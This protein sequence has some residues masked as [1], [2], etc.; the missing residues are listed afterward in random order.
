LISDKIPTNDCISK[1]VNGQWV[2]VVSFPPANNCVG[3]TTIRLNDGTIPICIWQNAPNYVE[4][5]ILTGNWCDYYLLEDCSPFKPAPYPVN[6][7]PAGCKNPLTGIA[8]WYPFDEN[9]PNSGISL[10]QSVKHNNGVWNGGPVPYCDGIVYYGLKFDGTS[11]YVEAPDFININFGNNQ[12]FSVSLWVKL[13]DNGSG[14][15]S[16]DTTEI[17]K[18]D[19]SVSS[20]WGDEVILDKRFKDRK[21]FKGY[22][23]V[24]F[25]SLKKFI[26]QLADGS[27]SNY[28][29]TNY[30]SNTVSLGTDWHLL[31]VVLRRDLGGASGIKWYIDGSLNRTQKSIKQGDLST[32]SSLIIGARYEKTTGFFNGV[33]DELQI[34]NRVL[35]ANEVM[36]IYNSKPFG[37]CKTH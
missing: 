1:N 29:F 11:S 21:Q 8:A 16:Q 17:S 2:D 18:M 30:S 15:M 20:T 23:L 14:F 35:D 13:S 33:M 31:T 7:G 22:H 36:S 6:F 24:Y 12:S 26:F 28:G 34:Y 25:H 9:D 5:D 37:F 3:G 4:N 10:D 19:L 27:S 32:T